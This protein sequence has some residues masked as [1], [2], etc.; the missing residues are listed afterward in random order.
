MINMVPLS[1]AAGIPD[2]QV[3]VLYGQLLSA[4]DANQDGQV[5]VVECQGIYADP[6][7][8]EQK[9]QYWDADGDGII[10]EDD[11]VQKVMN[12]GKKK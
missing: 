2:R 4:T 5:S 11:Y 12:M 10:T 3:R 1:H 6:V 7:L 8:A 9:C